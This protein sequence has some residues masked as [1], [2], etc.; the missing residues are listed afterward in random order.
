MFQVMLL[1]NFAAAQVP[2][3]DNPCNATP[4]TV[5][6]GC[7]FTQYTNLNATASPGVPAPGCA[8]YSGGDVWFSAVVPASGSLT[9]DCNTGGITDGGMAIY[10]GACNSL[11]LATRLPATSS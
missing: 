4:L 3:N 7:T 6:A 5:G 1:T 11:T 10:S 9:L 2:A 8:S